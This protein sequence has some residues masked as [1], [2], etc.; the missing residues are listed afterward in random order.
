ML[1]DNDYEDPRLMEMKN[2]LYQKNTKGRAAFETAGLAFK[3]DWVDSD[4]SIAPFCVGCVIYYIG[5]SLLHTT[6]SPIVIQI[7][8]PFLANALRL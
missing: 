7:D 8:S 3:D 5:L 2:C 6:L 1:D 4:C